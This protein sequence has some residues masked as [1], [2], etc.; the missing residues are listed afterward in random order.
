MPTFIDILYKVNNP[1]HK[2]VIANYITMYTYNLIAL[3]FKFQYGSN[4]R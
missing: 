2:I 3:L 1:G 4:F